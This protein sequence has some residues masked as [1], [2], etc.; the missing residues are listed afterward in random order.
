MDFGVSSTVIVVS[1]PGREYHTL[2]YPGISREFPCGAGNNPVHAI[3]SLVEY[4]NGKVLRVGDEVFRGGTM[5]E[6]STARWL[7]RYLCD[8]SSVQIPAGGDRR[9]RYEDAAGDFLA[10]LLTQALLL[11]PGAG[12]VFALP[13]DAPAEYGEFLQRV[14]RSAG[15]V[16]C[17]MI[18]EYT[19]ALAG[20]GCSPGDDEPVVLITFSETELEVAV[21]IRHYETGAGEEG[22]RVLA[23]AAGSMG[24]REMDGWIVQDLLHKFRLLESDPRAVRLMPQ[25]RAEASRLREQVSF[26]GQKEIHLTDIASGRAF[27]AVFT[28]VDLERIMIDHNIPSTIQDCIDR[29]LSTMRMRGAA[30]E[31]IQHVLLLGEG[32]CIPA[33]QDAVRARFRESEVNTE[34]PLDAVARG[35]AGQRAPVRAQD[36]ITC[37]Y[38]LRY[39]DAASKEHHYRYIV[40]SGSRYPSAGQVARIVISAAYDGQMCLGIPLYE[41]G[42][43]GEVVHGIELISEN[44]RGVRLA[45]PDQDADAQQQVVHANEHSPTLLMATPPARKGEPRFEC[46]F[47]IDAERNLCLS[48]RDLVTGTLVK[49]NA[50][51]YRMT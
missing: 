37:S 29:A 7:R 23:K 2:S 22:F 25:I 43:G 27:T 34:H 11:Y 49:V 30:R 46:T 36:R 5:D 16:S 31:R 26:T 15:A 3:P 8:R 39:W 32:G 18:N 47:T 24:C 41:I 6:P 44:G 9:V 19:A 48:A 51:I 42:G 28:E 33:V 14:A 21:L 20:Y 10:P 35:A 45:G 50:Q 40:H 17:S 4:Q 1:G 13:A 38:A 12:L